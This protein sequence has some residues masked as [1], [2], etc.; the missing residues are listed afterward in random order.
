MKKRLL[1]FLICI[2]LS[3]SA[4]IINISAATVE[5]GNIIIDTVSAL[6][7]DT[8]VVGISIKDNPGFAAL[9]IS[10]NYDS[11]V[12]EYEKY[13]TGFL[14]DYTVL[15]H[16]NDNIIRFVNC[17]SKNRKE[18]D[19]MISLQFKVNGDADTGFY[20]IT[21]TCN[22]GDISNWKLNSI[23]PTI[24]TGGVNVTFN[25]AKCSHKTYGEWV[26]VADAGCNEAGVKSHTCVKC[27][28]V[29]LAEIKSTGHQYSNEWTIDE[30]ATI[31]KDGVMSK[32]CKNCDSKTDI[33][34]FSYKQTE[35]TE[36]NNNIGS[37][38]KHN[39]LTDELV[40]EQLPD[41]ETQNNKKD[42]T[43]KKT[44]S[45]KDFDQTSKPTIIERIASIFEK[46][47][48]SEETTAEPTDNSIVDGDENEYENN[49]SNNNYK[50]NTSNS[51]NS[52]NRINYQL[53]TIIFVL[54]AILL[55]VILSILFYKKRKPYQKQGKHLKNQ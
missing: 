30:P 3:V 47:N 51:D 7:G 36:I 34:T 52:E 15:A 22:P 17:E 1:A 46:D 12:L 41:G 26:V 20:P 13:Y 40:K 55:I 50:T 45:N 2:L 4:T 8:V 5:A 11:S 19:K 6:S 39:E 23:M 29:E 27:Q 21:I 54:I 37:T 44:V 24:T 48:E 38:V 28:H 42:T 31:E 33:L 35:E 16:P 10:I 43:D 14:N 49:E 9:S 18:N 32:H 53:Y 25:K